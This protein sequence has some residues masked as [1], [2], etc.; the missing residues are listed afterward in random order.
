[1]F[2]DLTQGIAAA[3]GMS[4]SKGWYDNGI[5]N[6]PEKLMLIVTELSEARGCIQ[7]GHRLRD[8]WEEDGT[9]KPEGFGHE[10]ADAAIRVM[11]LAGYL[12]LPL[13]VHVWGTDPGLA[14]A[15]SVDKGIMDL[16]DDVSAAMEAY[17]KSAEADFRMYLELFVGRLWVYAH[18][19]GLDLIACIETKHAFNGTRPYRHGGKRA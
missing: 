17:R 11:D 5:P 19:W 9:G 7:D 4:R 13:S 12:N 3:H 1:M 8:L 10:L 16:V 14:V 2:R 6:V 15:P 18:H